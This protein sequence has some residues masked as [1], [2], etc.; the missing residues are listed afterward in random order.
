MI[1]VDLDTVVV[2]LDDAHAQHLAVRGLHPQ[3]CA[4]F[5][6]DIRWEIVFRYFYDQRFIVRAIGLIHF[7]SH[8]FLITNGHTG[9]RFLE[10]GDDHS[11]PEGK[12]QRLVP[13]A[14]R[15][16]D[17]AVFQFAGVMHFYGVAVF[18][19]SHVLL[20]F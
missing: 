12:L 20:L 4:E 11:L 7:Q 15:V 18:R 1:A 9:H 2:D 19:L 5:R 8:L 17:G 3:H 10:T 16:E 13:F 6:L 14:G